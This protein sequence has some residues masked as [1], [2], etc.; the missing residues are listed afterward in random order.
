M[1]NVLFLFLISILLITCSKDDDSISPIIAIDADK[2][3]VNFNYEDY[4]FTALMDTVSL[5]LNLT[6]TEEIEGAEVLIIWLVNGDTIKTEPG[7]FQNTFELNLF[8]LQEEYYNIQVVITNA[9]EGFSIKRD[10]LINNR[11]YINL[12]HPAIGQHSEF[13]WHSNYVGCDYTPEDS[14][15]INWE[16][17]SLTDSDIIIEELAQYENEHETT[18]VKIPIDNGLIVFKSYLNNN[19]DSNSVAFLNP[20]DLLI[21]FTNRQKIL[22]APDRCAYYLDDSYYADLTIINTVL[23]TAEIFSYHDSGH[24][25]IAIFDENNEFLG[26]SL[27]WTAPFG[28][29]VTYWFSR[30]DIQ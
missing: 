2:V 26:T 14:V 10:V 27:Y 6:Y 4:Y 3:Q 30:S 18:S 19:M 22:P 9:S 17:I 29:P 28:G 13:L 7:P 5:D 16:I 23:P 15:P 11:P 25:F 21:D 24:D 20:Y 12:E 8:N 1:K